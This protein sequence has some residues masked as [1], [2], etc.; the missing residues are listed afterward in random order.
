MGVVQRSFGKPR[1]HLSDQLEV[2]PLSLHQ[3]EFL[4]H[5]GNEVLLKSGFIASKRFDQ[6]FLISDRKQGTAQLLEIP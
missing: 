5:Q 2:F 3:A 6:M 4:S 1:Y